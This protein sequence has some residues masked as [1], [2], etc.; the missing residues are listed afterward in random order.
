MEG[1]TEADVVKAGA[2]KLDSASGSRWL[3][4]VLLGG[5]GTCLGLS[6]ILAKMA[7]AEGLSALAFLTWSLLIA[8]LSLFLRTMIN[9]RHR[10]VDA[11][12]LKYFFIA[13]L[14]SVA[15]P[16]L[17]LFTAVP[18]VGAGFASLTVAFPP[19]L[20]YV[21]ALALRM[22]RFAALRAS[23]VV[24]AL[25]GAAL[26]ATSK[27]DAPDAATVWIVAALCTPLFLAAGNIYRSARW[28]VGA[29]PDDLAPGMLIAAAFMLVVFGLMTGTSLVVPLD[30]VEP[31]MLVAIQGAAFSIQYVLFFQL[32]KISGP[33][34][35]S[36][37]GSVA[38]LVGVPMSVF[39]LGESWPGAIVPA[40]LLIGV[41]IALVSVRPRA[42]GT[43]A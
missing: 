12:T 16:N 13:A 37:L 7:F 29:E 31:I 15:A 18:H 43:N 30:R 8:S 23:G 3:P 38:A 1:D 11:A 22:E 41:G 40:A 20:T 32:Q 42:A 21:A 27:L 33:V 4:L 25:A 35:L 26:L 5:S 39:W 24:V 14:L 10:R 28:P 2:V 17:I 34:V 6:T 9:R 19:L 36:L